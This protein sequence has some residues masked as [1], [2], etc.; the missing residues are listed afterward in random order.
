MKLTKIET[1]TFKTIHEQISTIVNECSD[2]ENMSEFFDEDIENRIN[3]INEMI[4]L[5]NNEKELLNDL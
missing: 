5:L 2:I 1:K 3:E 4:L